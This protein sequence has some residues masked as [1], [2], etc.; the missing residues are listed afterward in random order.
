MIETDQLTPATPWPLLPT[1]P[2]V[3]DNVRSVAVVVHRIAVVV[4]EIVA[5]NVVDE[6]VAVVVFAVAGD[7]VG[8]RPD[9]RRKV[10]MG[11]VDAGVEH[12]HHDAWS[13]RW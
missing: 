10:A 11:V 7:F 1:A 5:V 4:D 8:V 6:A 13:C 3:P 12:R 9:V 2:I